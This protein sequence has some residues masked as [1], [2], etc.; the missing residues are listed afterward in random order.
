M[1]NSQ[2]PKPKI[3]LFSKNKTSTTFI[4]MR[5]N[6]A[7]LAYSSDS[8]DIFEDLSDNENN[9]E[10]IF[11]D[12]QIKTTSE[13]NIFKSYFSPKK[14]T[15][16]FKDIEEYVAN[17]AYDMEK[18]K[19]KHLNKI[20]DNKNKNKDKSKDKNKD[21]NKDKKITDE[22]NEIKIIND[23]FI[24]NEGDIE[25]SGNNI[26]DSKNKQKNSNNNITKFLGPLM[27]E[28]ENNKN[29]NMSINHNKSIFNSVKDL[30]KFQK[31][32]LEND[33]IDII[34]K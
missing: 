8:S 13:K 2:K 5:A 7:V 11:F 26:K 14:S 12:N 19:G 20:N 30:W 17:S 28:D 32:L 10:N 3:P 23:F 1:E 16:D 22:K 21:K 25:L 34:S 4:S 18:I 27:E 6:T 24:N 29:L 9:E 15:D 33:I 31:I